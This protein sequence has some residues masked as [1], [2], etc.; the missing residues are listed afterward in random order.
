MNFR[1]LDSQ[2]LAKAGIR[3]ETESETQAF[4]EV[5]RNELA[6]RIGREISKR[7]TKKQQREFRRRDN[8][9]SAQSWFDKNCP[10]YRVIVRQKSKEL[11]NEILIYK[12]IVS[13]NIPETIV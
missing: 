1:K 10:D 12:S 7:L 3:F 2:E 6:A 8:K 5:I 4:I 13:G 9:M 11:E